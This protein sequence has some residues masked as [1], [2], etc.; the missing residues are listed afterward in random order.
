MGDSKSGGNEAALARQEE[1]KRQ[2]QIRAGTKRVN[3]IFDTQFDD[4]FFTG[5]KDAYLNYA[6]P[7]LE[8]QYGQASKQLTFALDRAGQLDSSVRG[9]KMSELQKLFDTNKRGIADEAL[10]QE[11]SARNAVEDA[12]AGL[13]SS[14]NATGDAQGATS[15]ALARSQALSAPAAYSPL[16]QLFVDFTNG[17][18]IQAAQERAA[19]AGGAPSRYNTNLFGGAGRVRV[20]S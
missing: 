5:R 9:A 2:A 14:L 13:I 6:T 15:A 19:A 11:S 12:R 10:A 7:Q 17:L 16:T 20:T 18:G 1:Q 4:A 3:S 8:D